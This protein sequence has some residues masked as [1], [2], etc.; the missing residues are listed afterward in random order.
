MEGQRLVQ[1]PG[2]LLV[3]LFGCIMKGG[4]EQFLPDIKELYDNFTQNKSEKNPVYYA[5][6]FPM[7][8]RK[9]E[10]TVSLVKLYF[11]L[12]KFSKRYTQKFMVRFFFQY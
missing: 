2:S 10:C 9:A 3:C 12:N 4:R 1:D 6:A 5:F 7:E 8:T 11:L